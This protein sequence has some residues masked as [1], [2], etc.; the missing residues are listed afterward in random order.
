MRGSSDMGGDPCLWRPFPDSS[1]AGKEHGRII[2]L[3]EHSFLE[4]HQRPALELC[5]SLPEPDADRPKPATVTRI[6]PLAL[7]APFD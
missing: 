5:D 7:T 1:L 4:D 6:T 2:P 3:R